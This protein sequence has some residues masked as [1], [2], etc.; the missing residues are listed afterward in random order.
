MFKSIKSIIITIIVELIV[1]MIIFI[2]M[3]RMDYTNSTQYYKDV[4]IYKLDEQYLQV[5]ENIV[6]NITDTNICYLSFPISIYKEYEQGRVDLVDTK[7]IVNNQEI[8]SKYENERVTRI[9]STSHILN[10]NEQ[11]LSNINKD[12]T[13]SHNGDYI[14]IATK[15]NMNFE[16]GKHIITLS[17]KCAINDVITNYN[18]IAI[19]KM[20]RNTK[21]DKLNVTIT[22]PKTSSNFKVNSNKAILE[23]RD[24]KTYKVELSNVKYLE[25]FDYVGFVFENNMFLTANRIYQD[26]EITKETGIFANEEETNKVHFY[27]IAIIT[28][29]LFIITMIITKKEKIKKEYVRDTKT[30]ISPILAESLIDKKI[31]F[32]RTYNDMYC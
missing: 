32:K 25:K 26:Y 13:Y 10:N 6:V 9:K 4:N 15:N 31:R 28:N 7:V 11:L 30:V 29:I 3:F 23:N 22:F 1:I 16:T 17:Y 21:F 19:L 18:N 12:I 20:K 5:T 24:S 27:I 8:L 14:S 2:P